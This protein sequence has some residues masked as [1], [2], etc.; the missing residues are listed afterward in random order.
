MYQ[1]NNGNYY[2]TTPYTQPYQQRYSGVEQNGG[3][4][5]IYPQPQQ[6]MPSPYLKGRP[7]SS[8]EEARA[9]AVDFDGSLHIFTDIGNKKI[10]TKQ[11]N[12]DGT[13]TLR[14]Y[15]LLEDSNN[16]SSNTEYITRAEFEQTLSQLQASLL[17][18]AEDN[19]SATLN[20]F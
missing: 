13:A 20:N 14:T 18:K 2:N 3:I 4:A 15:V 11:I 10:Y 7:V 8:F 5:P 16:N 1:Q 19:K 9:A 12:V 6:S 17:A